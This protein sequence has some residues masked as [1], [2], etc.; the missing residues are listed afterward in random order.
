MKRLYVKFL[1]PLSLEEVEK[2]FDRWCFQTTRFPSP[3]ELLKCC[4]RSPTDR[5]ESQW[6]TLETY[7]D[8]ISDEVCRVHKILIEIRTLNHVSEYSA[9]AAK[10]DLKARFIALY[11][12]EWLEWWSR[13]EIEQGETIIDYSPKTT[14]P[15]PVPESE[16]AKP[17]D[18]KLFTSKLADLKRKVAIDKALAESDLEF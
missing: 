4:G 6:I 2:A 13:G 3:E 8:R 15:A 12:E 11:R 1:L 18:F 14:I 9:A 16:R 7:R 10:R 17:E 5:A